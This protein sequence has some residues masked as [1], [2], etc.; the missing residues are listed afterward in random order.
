M[1]F[2]K[3]VGRTAI[4]SF[5]PRKASIAS[6]CSLFKTIP[7]IHTVFSSP[8]LAAA[9]AVIH[10]LWNL[11]ASSYEPGQAGSVSEISPHYTF[12][13][14]NFD[15][16]IWEGGLARLLGFCDRDLRQPG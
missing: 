8:P 1:L 14:K 6:I 12:L 2:P 11:R 10:A 15:V 3:P 5:P 13:C 9:I 4:T 7:F 16:F